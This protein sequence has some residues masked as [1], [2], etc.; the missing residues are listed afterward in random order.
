[1]DFVREGVAKKKRIKAAILTVVVLAAGAAV[2]W[3]LSKLQA[4]GA[5]RRASHR[6]G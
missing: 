4:G 1:M 6:L 3:R 5:Q 2:T